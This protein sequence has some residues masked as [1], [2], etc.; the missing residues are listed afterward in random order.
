[1]SRHPYQVL[2]EQ[3]EEGTAPKEYALHRTS[4]KFR[5]TRLLPS[6]R[7]ALYQEDPY[8]LLEHDLKLNDTVLFGLRSASIAY[9]SSIPGDARIFSS[10]HIPHR[11]WLDE[12]PFEITGLLD[13][14][15][16]LALT[17]L[18]VVYNPVTFK[19]EPHEETNPTL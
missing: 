17:V 7:L 6:E 13:N 12:H 14:D 10:Y 11:H 18:D 19:H 15:A 9:R 3:L 5:P 8:L 1:M 4:A 16:T 2:E